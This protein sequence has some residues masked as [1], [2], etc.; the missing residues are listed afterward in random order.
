MSVRYKTTVYLRG[1]SNSCRSTV[2]S[3]GQL[4]FV[5]ISLEASKTTYMFVTPGLQTSFLVWN[6]SSKYRRYTG[7]AV[8]VQRDE[9]A[10]KYFEGVM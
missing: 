5:G 6:S 10:L 9:L 1:G 3:V 8:R 4:P 2:V 7:T